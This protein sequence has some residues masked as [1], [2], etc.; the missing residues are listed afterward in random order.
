M[1]TNPK[2]SYFQIRVLLLIGCVTILVALWLSFALFGPGELIDGTSVVLG[3]LHLILLMV[4]LFIFRKES[5]GIVYLFVFSNLVVYDQ[6]LF[7]SYFFPGMGLYARK[8]FLTVNDM[9]LALVYLVVITTVALGGFKLGEVLIQRPHEIRTE[10]WLSLPSNRRLFYLIGTVVN[11]TY[12]VLALILF[13]TMGK[14]WSD[15]LIIKILLHLIVFNGLYVYVCVVIMMHPKIMLKRSDRYGLFIVLFTYVLGMLVT[16]QKGAFMHILL[17]FIVAK[18][19]FGD[20]RISRRLAATVVLAVFLLLF[21][22]PLSTS[23][24]G[25][26]FSSVMGREGMQQVFLEG[27]RIDYEGGLFG[28][29][30]NLSLR[31][32]GMEWFCSIMVRSDEFSEY[33]NLENLS[34]S[35]INTFVPWP[36]RVFPNHV[37]VGRAMQIVIYG[38]SYEDTEVIGGYPMLPGWIYVSFG[39]LGGMVF[40]FLWGLVGMA[41]VRSNW[42]IIKKL[43]FVYLFVWSFFLSGDLVPYIKDYV[44]F[45]ATLWIITRFMTNRYRVTQ[46]APLLDSRASV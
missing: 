21:M 42:G 27:F 24:R 5:R 11:I 22:F 2:V 14:V 17:I 10:E 3:T 33:F 9:N 31:L 41:V 23:I 36:G 40:M 28:Q 18:L 8:V 38:L 34:K 13:P 29:V 46:E 6:S 45:L 32:G 25:A 44:I 7:Y 15:Q 39:W 30:Q 20:Y 26:M 16:G 37:D 35:I 43:I 4:G 1:A 19:L 12:L